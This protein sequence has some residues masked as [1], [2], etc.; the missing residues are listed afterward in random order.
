MKKILFLITMSVFILLPLSAQADFSGSA[1]I[2]I[3]ANIP[4]SDSFSSL[5]SRA[6]LGIEDIG[7]M[8]ALIAKLDAGDES[9]IFS[10]WF[11]MKEFPDA[12]WNELYAFDLM[13]LSAI[14]YLTDNISIEIGRQSMLTGYGYGW[15]PIDF[16]NPLKNPA[17]PDAD[18]RGVDGAALRI[19][20]GD[21]TSLKLYGIIPDSLLSS[22]LDY[23][24]IKA[25]T[26]MALNLPGVEVKLAGFWDYD[27]SEG[28]D[29]YTPAAGAA[30][31]LDLFGVGVYGEAATRKGSRNY[32]TD[33]VSLL[34]RKTDWLISG[35]AGLEY[36]FES[37]LYAVIEYFYNGE[38][39]DESD[40]ADFQTALSSLTV[41][42]LNMYSPGYFA[43]HYILV[44]L[45][46]P[47]Y[48]FDTDLN[49]SVL[50]SP[51]SGALTL[52]PS[53]NYLFS[54]NF[55]ANL[56]YTGLFDLGDNDFNEIT[57]LPVRHIVS[58][59][60]TYSY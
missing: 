60:F 47:F 54:G 13:R 23:E 3:F 37:E 43:Q 52:M 18:L 24:E 29:A 22:G 44:N 40:R 9:T 19:Y 20:L 6:D 50:Y 26:E 7:M 8:S 36:T 5:L 16:A 48:D 59:V 46:Q 38:G 53:I 39:Y 1:D 30:I 21:K 25:G 12:L 28:S 58:T 15:N 51:D 32:F 17:D 2:T 33:G 45:L 41:D 42:L 14:V 34:P 11:S 4:E 10:A 57:A 49:I 35:L 27:N 55:S 56:A 31:I